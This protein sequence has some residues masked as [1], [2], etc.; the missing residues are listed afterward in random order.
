MQA[1][2]STQ[3]PDTIFALSSGALPSGV[4]VLRVS[5]SRSRDVHAA[6][7]GDEPVARRAATRLVRDADGA[8]L[9]QAVVLWFEAPAS[10]TG[11]DVLELHVHGGRATVAAL[12]RRLGTMPGLRMAEAGE[13]TRRAF[14]NGKLDLTQAEAL[15]D[16]IAAETEAQ[17][18][19]A[20]LSAQ[21]GQRELYEGWRTR[22]VHARAMIEAELDFADE[23]DVPGSVAGTIWQD[24]RSL[25]LEIDRHCAGFKRAEIV[26]D[27]YDVVILGAPNSGKSSLINTLAKR[28]AAI[29]SD[30]PGTTRDL[31]EVVLDLDGYKVRVTDTAGLRDTSS[32]VEQ[33]GI[34]RARER[35]GQA[36]LVL[37]LVPQD[38][39]PDDKPVDRSGFG[40]EV[41]LVG[42]KTDLPGEAIPGLDIHVSSVTGEGLDELMR[43][44][45]ERARNAAGIQDLLPL[46]ERHIQLLKSAGAA[47]AEALNDR[48][49]LE[50][51]A[52]ALRDASNAVGRITGRVD[53]EDLLE[54]IFSTFCVGK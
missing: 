30:E 38:A 47:I 44:L 5:G 2:R 8:V 28:E 36:D 3:F 40:G 20:M 43:R 24:M 49:P 17:R 35:A 12:L 14:L 42:T 21:G 16:L 46:R 52:E 4:A 6:L 51:R 41:L 34:R 37:Y 22:L 25:A 10:F 13:F 53:V 1:P 48:L 32:A 26:R 7:V 50:L 9:D 11:E 33:I 31:I 45:A 15:S 19:L 18:K 23:G 39:L 54:V 27:G 29:V